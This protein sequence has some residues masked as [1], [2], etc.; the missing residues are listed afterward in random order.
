[1]LSR[2]Q[3]HKYTAITIPT[4]KVPG[5]KERVLVS[6]EVLVLSSRFKLGAKGYKSFGD[7]ERKLSCRGVVKWDCWIRTL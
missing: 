5:C 6:D 7:S 3:G 2:K 1:M 4:V